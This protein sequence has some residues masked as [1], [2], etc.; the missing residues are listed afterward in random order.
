MDNLRGALL[1]VLAMLGFAIED[2]F[3]KLLSDAVPIGQILLMLGLGG[4]LA[5]GTII[6]LR[7]RPILTPDLLC[8]PILLRAIGEVVGTLG[9]VS[10]FVLTEISTTSAIFQATPLAV[11]MGAAVFLGEPVGWRRW[12]AIFVGLFGVILIIRPGLEGFEPL[13]LLA[14]LAVVSLSM[15]DLATRKVPKSISSMQLSFLG[16]IVVAPAGLGLMIATNGTYVALTPRSW[17]LIGGSVFFGFFAY[18][19][20]VSATRIGDVGFVTPFRYTRLLFA[21]VVGVTVFGESPDTL[22]LVGAAIIVASG[23][24]T[25]LRERKIRATPLSAFPTEA[26]RAKTG[27]T[28]PD[29]KESP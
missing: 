9:F 23:I 4:G 29:A 25:V 26:P 12:S 27:A 18:Y 16:M 21:L 14:L 22:T 24:Y 11:A 10:A 20:I 13:S 17:M 15:R 8:L 1:M 19:A 5:F 3:I 7:G 28:Q 2:T 6:K